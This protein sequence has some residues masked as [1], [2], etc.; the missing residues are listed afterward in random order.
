[1]SQGVSAPRIVLFGSHAQGNAREDSDIDVV[2]ISDAFAGKS[3]WERITLLSKAILAGHV[4][5][6]AVPMTESEWEGGTSLI[7]EFAR[8]GEEIPS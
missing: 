1:V 4:L 6:E 3:H 2:V 5:I 7:A 8:D